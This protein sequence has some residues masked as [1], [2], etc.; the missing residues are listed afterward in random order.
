MEYFENNLIFLISSGLEFYNNIW[1]KITKFMFN[2]ILKDL[3]N[4]NGVS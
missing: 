4:E 3:F 2:T 1:I